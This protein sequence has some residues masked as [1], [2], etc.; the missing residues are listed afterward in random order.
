A[1]WQTVDLS[2]SL[3]QA[4]EKAAT[5][6]GQRFAGLLRNLVSFGVDLVL[7]IFALFFMFRDGREILR[8]LRHLMPFEDDIQ[9][10]VLGESKEL[11][12]ASVA[13]ALVIAAI[14]GS[15]G[16]LAFA[17]T[18]VPTPL[19]WGVLIGFFSLVPVVGSALIWVPAAAWLGFT[20][21]WGK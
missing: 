5:F 15:L 17:I 19:F 2:D 20:G 7:L 16:A 1:S 4:A 21:H 12:F 18:G 14:Q 3:R 10:E 9:E 8:G 11:I 6:L 13:V